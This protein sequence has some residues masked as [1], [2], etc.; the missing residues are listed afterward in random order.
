MGLPAQKLT[1]KYAPCFDLEET[2]MDR[3]WPDTHSRKRHIGGA[4][5]VLCGIAASGDAVGPGID[6]EQTDAATVGART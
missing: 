6:K 3:L 2:L 4:L 5:A 1:P